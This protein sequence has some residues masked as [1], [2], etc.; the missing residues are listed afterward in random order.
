M[1]L[2]AFGPGTY[3]KATHDLFPAGA[4]SLGMGGT[5]VMLADEWSGA[6]N[7]AGL[8][9]V[10]QF[11]LCLHGENKFL[12]PET[13]AG[14]FSM[15]IPVQSGTFGL[16]YN[17][18]GYSFYQE[19]GFCLAFGKSFGKK[20][21]A[22]IGLHYLKINQAAGYDNLFTLVPAAGIQFLPVKGLVIGLHAFNPAEQ[23]YYPYGRMQIPAIFT[24]GAA[25]MLGDGLLICI[26]TEKESHCT[27]LI[28]GGLEY[29]FS[30]MLHARF[31]ISAGEFPMYSFGLGYLAGKLKM[32]ISVSRHF[33]LGF[34]PAV[35]FSYTFP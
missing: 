17:C 19:C 32:D 33:L 21:R 3:S 9:A 22:G 27:P 30:K 1:L 29:F 5:F 23:Q 14:A 28:R 24:L 31:G 2:L 15:C 13:G 26:E 10:N 4:R 7:Q 25:L 16:A 35:T 6:L 8:G 12:V 20:F 34:S 18:S 11:T